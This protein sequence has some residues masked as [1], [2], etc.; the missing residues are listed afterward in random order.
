MVVAVT[1]LNGGCGRWWLWRSWSHHRGG[2]GR[3]AS[4]CSGCVAWQLRLWSHGLMMA[5]AGG[6]SG[7]HSC[8]TEA[9][10]VVSHCV[11]VAA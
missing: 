1:W 7:S 8:V 11:V 2:G 10:A 3:A 9:V 5:V 6:G 4:C